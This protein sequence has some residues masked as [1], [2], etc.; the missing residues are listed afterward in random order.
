MHLTHT[1]SKIPWLIP[2]LTIWQD[3]L[4]WPHKPRMC[5]LWW[6][7][8]IVCKLNVSLDSAACVR[9]SSVFPAMCVSWAS[10]RGTSCRSIASSLKFERQR[11][12]A[13]WRSDYLF[14]NEFHICLH[15]VVF[16]SYFKTNYN[17]VYVFCNILIRFEIRKLNLNSQ[18][19]T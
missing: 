9:R 5:Y 17:F 11:I 13:S 19:G 6:Y 1:S 7:Y 16:I 14:Q 12:M 10:I 18:P 8:S 15:T 3:I 2:T 4:L